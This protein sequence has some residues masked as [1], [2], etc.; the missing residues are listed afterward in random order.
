[1]GVDVPFSIVPDGTYG[2][3]LIVPSKPLSSG[4]YVMTRSEACSY[5]EPTLRSATITVGDVAAMPQTIG[6]LSMSP[7]KAGSI[8]IGDGAQ[9]CQQEQPATALEL[10]LVPTPEITAW[11]SLL[12]YTLEIDGTV[13]A[14][15]QYGDNAFDRIDP[16]LF[17]RT[18]DQIFTS[19]DLPDGS[20]AYR[21]GVTPGTHH[22][23]LSAHV[24]GATTDPTPI[25]FDFTL[26]CDAASSADGGASFDDGGLV[27]APFVKSSGCSFGG[28][29]ARAP[30]LLLPLLALA[31][32]RRRLRP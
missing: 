2:D 20:S 17:E 5:A 21:A 30:W 10:S 16:E 3:V 24:A 8:F 6:V 15:S 22:A 7:G 18:V 13:W 29:S 12:H 25:A 27:V 19:C 9:S 1:D 14:T 11:G 28:N 32:R 26:T 4:T 23:V 31:L